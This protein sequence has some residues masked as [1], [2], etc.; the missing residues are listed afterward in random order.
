MQLAQQA[1]TSLLE[2]VKEENQKATVV[3]TITA[4]INHVD[5]LQTVIKVR[6]TIYIPYAMKLR[7]FLPLL[8]IPVG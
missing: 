4:T 1:A 3:D 5:Y 6:V 7:T 2:T 8:S